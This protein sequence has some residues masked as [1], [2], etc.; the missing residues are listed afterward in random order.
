MHRCLRYL[1]YSGTG[2]NFTT[3]FTCAQ[4]VARSSS[5]YGPWTRLGLVAYPSLIPGTWNKLRVDSGRAQIVGG[6]RGYW[7][8]GVEDDPNLAREGLYL[9]VDSSSFAPPY[10]QWSGNPVWSPS[11][12]EPQAG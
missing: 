3:N 12:P 6:Q 1:F 8:K 9:P 11:P 7:T 2:A 5:P 10:T 4:L